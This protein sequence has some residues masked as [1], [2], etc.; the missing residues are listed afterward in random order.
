MKLKCSLVC[1]LSVSQL[2]ALHLSDPVD[3]RIMLIGSVNIF[4]FN[5]IYNEMNCKQY[6]IFE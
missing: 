4:T 5:L 6:W 3:G 1:N 2:A